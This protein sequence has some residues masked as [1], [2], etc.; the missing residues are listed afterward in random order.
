MT[1]FRKFEGEVLLDM[2]RGKE[3]ELDYIRGNK[4]R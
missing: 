1:L 2:N 4:D 3:I